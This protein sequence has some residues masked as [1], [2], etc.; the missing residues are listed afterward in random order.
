MNEDYLVGRYHSPNSEHGNAFEI[1]GSSL[2]SQTNQKP[3][4]VIHPMTKQDIFQ[5]SKQ[6]ALLLRQVYKAVLEDRSHRQILVA[7]ETSMCSFVFHCIEPVIRLL[8]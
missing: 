4:W 6:N 3:L 8:E 2:I 7:S 5:M 1:V